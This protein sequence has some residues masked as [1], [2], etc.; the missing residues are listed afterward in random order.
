MAQALYKI[1]HQS[2]P[3]L[4]VRTCIHFHVKKQKQN[5]AHPAVWMRP[6]TEKQ[7]S[8]TIGKLVQ[9]RVNLLFGPVQAENSNATP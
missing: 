9:L 8:P 7:W 4:P 5:T 3:L 2:V 6:T 1:N